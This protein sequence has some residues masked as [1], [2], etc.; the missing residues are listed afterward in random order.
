M[1]PYVV[2][3]QR[4][5]KNVCVCVCTCVNKTYTP[6]SRGEGNKIVFKHYSACGHCSI[7]NIGMYFL[8]FK[9]LNVPL[10]EE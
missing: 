5:A 3:L 9:Y 2:F 4:G 7:P 10:K 8:S 1:I 6:E